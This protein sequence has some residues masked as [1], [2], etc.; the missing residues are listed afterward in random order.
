VDY[1]PYQEALEHIGDIPEWACRE[2]ARLVD[3]DGTIYNGPEAAYKALWYADQ[4][5]GLLRAYDN[6]DLFRY[7]SDHGYT[8]IARHRVFLFSITKA[9]WGKN[10][11]KPKKY[12]LYYLLGIIAVLLGAVFIPILK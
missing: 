7:L 11:S 5:R 6:S 4:W 9:L 3:I 2:A 10:P 12:W 1:E 8:W